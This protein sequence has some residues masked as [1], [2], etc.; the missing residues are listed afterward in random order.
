[1][2]KNEIV[3]LGLSLN[4]PSL[5]SFLW[6]GN[7]LEK[8]YDTGFPPA[9]TDFKAI[10]SFDLPCDQWHKSATYLADVRIYSATQNV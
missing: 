10:T 7:T 5:L 2:L 4:L 6:K 9:E 8:D 1:M 3:T